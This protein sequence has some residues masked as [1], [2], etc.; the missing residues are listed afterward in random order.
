METEIL[1]LV[2]TGNRF[3]IAVYMQN[4]KVVVKDW[5]AWKLTADA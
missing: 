4:E 5:T 2:E 1:W 3:G